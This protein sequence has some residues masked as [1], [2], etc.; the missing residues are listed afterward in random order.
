MV[1]S[2]ARHRDSQAAASVAK[3]GCANAEPETPSSFVPAFGNR[4]RQSGR[5]GGDDANGERRVKARGEF[6]ARSHSFERMLG[7]RGA[8]FISMRKYENGFHIFP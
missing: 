4:A 6:N 7:K 2:A 1:A 3:R 5:V 8:G